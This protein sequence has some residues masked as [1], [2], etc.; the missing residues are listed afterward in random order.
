MCIYKHNGVYKLVTPSAESDQHN[1]IKSLY[2][3]RY[4]LKNWKMSNIGWCFDFF[5]KKKI[6]EYLD[7]AYGTSFSSMAPRPDAQKFLPSRIPWQKFTFSYF[8]TGD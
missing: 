3:I 8:Q 7:A 5:V 4:A 2:S 1:Q 6:K